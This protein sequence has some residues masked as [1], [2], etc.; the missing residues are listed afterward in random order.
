V[1]RDK[2]L[3]KP[4]G[5]QLIVLIGARRIECAVLGGTG[6]RAQWRADSLIEIAIPASDGAGPPLDALAAALQQVRAVPAGTEMR[7]V[8]ADSWLAAATVPWSPALQRPAGAESAA[9]ARLAAAGFRI[10]Q[11]D[12]VRL[13]E[14]PFGAPRLAIGY[15]AALLGALTQAAARVNARLASVLPLSV[16]GWTLARRNGRG[17]QTALAL[18]DDGFIALARG[19]RGG[20]C[21]LDELTVRSADGAPEAG[22][23]GLHALWQR[24]CLRDP[25][26]AAVADVAM[27]D[28]DTQRGALPAP[29][30]PFVLLDVPAPGNGPAATPGLSLAAHG[31]LRRDPLDALEGGQALS[32]RRA[33]LLAGAVLLAAAMVAQ[34]LAAARSVRALQ[35][36]LNTAVSSTAAAPR[37]VSWSRAELARVQA[38]NIAIRELN[39][40][41]SA[42]LRALV[43]PPD[44]R[45]AVLSVTTAA[46]R[47][48]AQASSVKIVAEARTGAEMARYVAFLAERKPLTGAYL[49]EHEIDE[50]SAERPYRFTLEASW[51]D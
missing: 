20:R 41:F 29:G 4:A 47:S 7:V 51:S 50:T 30:K 14:A 49:T 27:L 11:G 36:R 18:L 3:L 12:T 39:L 9:R 2:T 34:A 33:L 13:D 22:R 48:G 43:P 38:A 44:L 23:H 21:R 6:T 37:A 16:A 42:I 28:L 17:T 24:L 10:E 40:P 32:V 26:L 35:A 45:V 8:V 1:L 25:Q 31:R 19:T 46:S 5:D 15:P